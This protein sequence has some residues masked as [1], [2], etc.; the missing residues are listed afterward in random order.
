MVETEEQVR[1]L[2]DLGATHAQGY[3]FGKPTAEPAGVERRTGGRVGRRS[4]ARELW[5]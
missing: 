4:G 2:R 1:L 5:A 3:L